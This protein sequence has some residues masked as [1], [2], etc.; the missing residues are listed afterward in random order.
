[1]KCLLTQITPT[2]KRK[3]KKGK[4]KKKLLLE[5]DTYPCSPKSDEKMDGTLK[6][7]K[8]ENMSSG[9]TSGEEGESVC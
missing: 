4:A 7:E 8:V 1:M 3:K 6:E 2:A 5:E 9:E